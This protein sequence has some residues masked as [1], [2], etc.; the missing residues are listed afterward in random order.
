MEKTYTFAQ[1]VDATIMV[2]KFKEQ[3]DSEVGKRRLARRRARARV[4][5]VSEITLLVAAVSLW[6]T[7]AAASL[8]FVKYF[9]DSAVFG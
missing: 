6:A 4:R 7:C 5:I 1:D 8:Y 9:V 3:M 2:A